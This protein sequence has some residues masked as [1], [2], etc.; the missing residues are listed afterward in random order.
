MGPKLALPTEPLELQLFSKCE[1]VVELVLVDAHLPLVQEV[2]DQIQVEGLQAPHVDEGIL[3]RTLIQTLLEQVLEDEAA[4]SKD[5]LV[6]LDL[7]TIPT[8]KSHIRELFV[9]PQFH[10][11]GSDVLY[12][13]VPIQTKVLRV[14]RF[15]L[16]ATDYKLLPKT[17][18]M[19]III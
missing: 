5:H 7:L 8:G 1:E 10:K 9:S 17:I 15:S 13:V 14:H 12:K 16:S 18:M 11:G 4:R 3:W 2:H 6:S 19:D